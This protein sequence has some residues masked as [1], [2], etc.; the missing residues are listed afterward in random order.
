[1]FGRELESSENRLFEKRL[2]LRCSIGLID[3][4]IDHYFAFIG[5]IIL[6]TRFFAS[7][8]KNYSITVIATFSNAR[9]NIESARRI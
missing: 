8:V 5:S 3:I 6:L 2:F 4:N 7:G 9:A 1:M